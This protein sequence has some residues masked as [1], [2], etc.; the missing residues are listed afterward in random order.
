MMTVIHVCLFVCMFV[1]VC[2]SMCCLYEMV[3]LMMPALSGEM[4]TLMMPALSGG[5][6]SRCHTSA[7]RPRS[8]TVQILVYARPPRLFKYLRPPITLF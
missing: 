5:G 3:T 6:G 8:G 1:C 4:V 2:V 7:E